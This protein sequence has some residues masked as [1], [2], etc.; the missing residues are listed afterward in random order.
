MHRIVFN[1]VITEAT[2]SLGGAHQLH[3]DLY[4]LMDA[5]SPYT[6]RPHAYFR[7][8]HEACV[9]LTCPGE[10][11]AYLKDGLQTDPDNAAF[12]EYLRACGIHVLQCEQISCILDERLN[13]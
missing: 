7:E 13:Y 12:V 2:F 1:D 10:T 8:L 9:L 3:Y 5:F 6:Q 11:A 4:A